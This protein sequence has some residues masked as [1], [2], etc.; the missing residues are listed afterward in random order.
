ME[1]SQRRGVDIFEK[2][3]VVTTLLPYYS[4]NY[5]HW[6]EMMWSYN[7]NSRRFYK[8][9]HSKLKDLFSRLEVEDR[10]KMESKI[11]KYIDPNEELDDK[12]ILHLNLNHKNEDTVSFLKEANSLYAIGMRALFI[13]G[14]AKASETDFKWL[15]GF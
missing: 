7:K 3:P 10:E 6:A 11:K 14:L 4:M 12:L 13:V 5:N 2:L 1:P 8:D 15:S 9:N